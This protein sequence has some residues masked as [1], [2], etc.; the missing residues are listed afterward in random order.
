MVF[1]MTM[2]IDAD[3]LLASPIFNGCR[4]SIGFHPLHSYLA[5]IVYALMLAHSKLRIVAIGL[6]MHI[7]TDYI[8]CL[9]SNFNGK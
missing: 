9:F 2:L 6:L 1:L 5:I 3:H 4:C 7:A 8:D